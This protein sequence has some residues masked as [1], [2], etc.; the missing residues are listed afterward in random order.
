MYNFFIF[1]FMKIGMFIV[2][3]SGKLYVCILS[4]WYDNVMCDVVKKIMLYKILK[5]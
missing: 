3:F 2:F 5:K 1:G 4:K